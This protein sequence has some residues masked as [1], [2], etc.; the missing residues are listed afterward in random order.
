MAAEILNINFC[1]FFKNITFSDSLSRKI[2]NKDI[3]E[4]NKDGKLIINYDLV[5]E[6][7]KKLE[8][9]EWGIWKNINRDKHEKNDIEKQKA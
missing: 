9:T 4:K 5:L 7:F 3:I 6:I 2:I 1:E 8:Y